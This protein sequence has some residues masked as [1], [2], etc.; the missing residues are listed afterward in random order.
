MWNHNHVT[1][2]CNGSVSDSRSEDCLFKSRWGH[3]FSPS[4][5][6]FDE[7]FMFELFLTSLSTTGNSIVAEWLRR[8]TQ[9]QISF[10]SADLNPDGYDIP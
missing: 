4:N 8:L 5:L 1:Q 9:N 6:L 3:S 7:F 10:E 2:W